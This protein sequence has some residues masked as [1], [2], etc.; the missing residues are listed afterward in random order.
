MSTPVIVWG[1]TG[2]ARVLADFLPA[3]GY[4]IECFIDRD[5]TVVSP[6]RGIPVL[7]GESGFREWM[8]AQKQ[9]PAALVAIGGERGEDRLD[10]QAFMRTAGCTIL[11]VV[12]PRAV[13]SERAQL[14]IGTQVLAGAVVG[15]D[16]QIG[17]G[18]IVNTRASVDHECRLGDGVHL[19]PGVTLCGL[20]EVGRLTFIGAGAVVLPRVRIGSGSVIGAGS[21]VTRDISDNIV[22]YGHPARIIRPRLIPGS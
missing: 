7:L 11:T 2:Q 10:R 3:L 6:V 12:H 15:P 5:P 20:V 19:A 18:V 22:A 4:R 16:S 1:A 13:V 17:D 9:A 8:A 21:L 14:G